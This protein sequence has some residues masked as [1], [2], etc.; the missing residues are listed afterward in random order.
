MIWLYRLLFPL[1]FLI[2]LPYYLGRMLRRGGY[3]E[4]FGDRFG[5]VPKPDLYRSG[6]TLWIQAVSVGEV[7]AIEPVIHTLR[8]SLPTARIILT[9]TTSTGYQL[10]HEKGVE[11]DLIAYFPIDFW[12]ISRRVW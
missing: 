11:A 7:L 10:A 12:P 4:R 5:F 9:T 3:G 6:P 8:R 1:L 2:G